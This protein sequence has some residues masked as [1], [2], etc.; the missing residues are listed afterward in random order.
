MRN[1]ATK[2]E[3]QGILKKQIESSE[4]Y[5]NYLQKVYEQEIAACMVQL[6]EKFGMLLRSKNLM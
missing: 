4:K 6:Q 5:A 1:K 3:I 2:E